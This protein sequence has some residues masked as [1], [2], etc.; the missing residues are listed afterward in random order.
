MSGTLFR[1]NE[2]ARVNRLLWL[3]FVGSFLLIVG[4]VAVPVRP[5]VW[6]FPA[7]SLVVLAAVFGTIVVSSVAVLQYEWPPKREGQP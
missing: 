7:W 5:L 3:T 2:S 4:A 1:G 6:A